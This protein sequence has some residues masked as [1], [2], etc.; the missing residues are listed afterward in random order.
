MAEA[1]RTE[2]YN[3]NIEN[4][5]KV[6]TDYSSYPD[7][8]DGV[9]GVDVQSM[10]ESGGKV[11]YHLNMIKK[12]SYTLSMSHQRPQKVSWSF[13]SGDLFAVNEGSWEFKDLGGDKTE[14]TYT[15]NVDF[16]VKVPKMILSK[17]A[18]K[19]LPKMM[20]SVYERAKCL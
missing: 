15:V 17:L 7:F 19:N 3:A 9:S 10:D 13:D 1:T 14:V 11:E 12:F 4:F 16:K 18:G 6:V 8:M 2:T 20:D 5:F